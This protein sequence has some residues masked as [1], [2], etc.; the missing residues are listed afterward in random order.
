MTWIIVAYLLTLAFLSVQQEK[1]PNSA[2]LQKAWFF[3]ALAFFS[4][5]VVTLYQANNLRNP[6]D[7]MCGQLWQEGLPF[8]FIGISVL[9]LSKCFSKN[10]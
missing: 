7:I 2:G 10:P 5:V 3:F 4:K 9:S 1:L 6:R 8:L